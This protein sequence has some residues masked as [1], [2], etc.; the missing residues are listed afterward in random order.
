MCIRDRSV[1]SRRNTR[2]SSA[3]E[4]SDAELERVFR[5]LDT[6]SDGRVDVAAFVGFFETGARPEVAGSG[7]LL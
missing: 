3:S 2:S 6:D 7:E 1:S 4:L 5:L